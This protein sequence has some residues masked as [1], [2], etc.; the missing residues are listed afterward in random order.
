MRRAS[1]SGEHDRRQGSAARLGQGYRGGARMTTPQARAS[2]LD[3]HDLELFN[4]SL[5][6]CG[7]RRLL[8][9]FYDLF[10]SASQEVAAKFAHTDFTA[11]KRAVKASFYMI[12]SAIEQKPEGDVHL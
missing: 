4:D 10:V 8:D 5:E 1:G 11:Q 7:G 3:E 2:E 12:M 6:R 9:R